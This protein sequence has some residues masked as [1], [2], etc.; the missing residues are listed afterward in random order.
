MLRDEEKP[1]SWI[2]QIARN[3]IAD[4]YREQRTTTDALEETP[5]LCQKSQLMMTP[6]KN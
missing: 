5:R 2:Y 3:A 4:Y 1:Q 6:S